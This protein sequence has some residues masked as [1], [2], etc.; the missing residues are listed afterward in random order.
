MTEGG[1]LWP[2]T[3]AFS[4]Q[5]CSG[6]QSVTPNFRCRRRTQAGSTQEDSIRGA[7]T[8]EASILAVNT[9]EGS[10]REGSILVANIRSNTRRG[11]IRQGNTL[12]QLEFPRQGCLRRSPI[13]RI[14]TA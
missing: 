10:T 2:E 14:A 8:R 6:R 12:L 1:S 13:T 11:S 3:F 5:R 4:F 9:R 7:N